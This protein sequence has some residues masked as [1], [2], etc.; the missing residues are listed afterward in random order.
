M[1]ELAS[2]KAYEY[3]SD[4]GNNQLGDGPRYKG[5]G[6][7][8]LTGRANYQD[9]CDYMGDPRIM[10][11]VEYVANTYPFTSAGFWWSNNKM[12]ALCDSGASVEKVTRRVNGGYNGLEDRKYYYARTVE[13]I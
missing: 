13:V 12:N 4:L 1:K 8:Q 11:G 5:A 6:Y 10:D 2:G 9:F 3:R 7:I